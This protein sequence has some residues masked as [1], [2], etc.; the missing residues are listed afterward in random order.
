MWVNTTVDEVPFGGDTLTLFK[1]LAKERSDTALLESMDGNGLNNRQS[2]LFIN[3]ALRIEARNTTVTIVA[4]SDNG[5]AAIAA[6]RPS[7]KALGQLEPTTDQTKLRFSKVSHTGSDLDRIKAKSTLDT[8]RLLCQ[9]WQCGAQTPM[10]IHAPGIFSYDHL[11]QFEELPKAREDRLDF[12]SF[13]FWLPERMVILNHIEKKALIVTHTFGED[14]KT[15]T[16]TIETTDLVDIIKQTNA[17]TI[18]RTA[19]KS[20]RGSLP[21]QPVDVDISDA[22]YAALVERLKAHIIKGDVFQIVASRT[23]SKSVKD[24]AAVYGTLRRLNPSPYMFLVKAKTF[25][26]FGAS[27][28]ACVRAIGNPRKEEIHPIG[29]NR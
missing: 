6:A 15:E 8:I 29:S 10:P 25:T 24:P 20:Q 27:P 17:K 11:E 9:G 18:T 16:K 22:E 26:L 2:L 21:P 28:E 5:K 4:L 23:F 3:S 7:L 13:V 1:A 12:P 14:S 19:N